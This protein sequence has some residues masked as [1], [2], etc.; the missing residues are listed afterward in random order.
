MGRG[1]LAGVA[2]AATLVLP[3]PVMAAGKAHNIAIEGM[4]FVPERLEVQ[5]GDTVTWSN[6]DLVPHTV[7][8]A[9]ASIESGSIAPG[10][11]WKLTVRRKGQ[12]DYT[13]RFHPVMHG[14]LEVR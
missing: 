13:C 3:G 1:L 14:T 11:S 6:K 4:K 2:L 7:T 9:K 5:A 8:A 10:A 12:I